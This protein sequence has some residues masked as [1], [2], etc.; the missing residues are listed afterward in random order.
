MELNRLGR[1]YSR[2][3]HLGKQVELNFAE[4]EDRMLLKQWNELVQKYWES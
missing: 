2:R 4:T 3:S 1:F